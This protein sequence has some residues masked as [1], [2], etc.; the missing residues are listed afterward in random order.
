MAEKTGTPWASSMVTP[1]GLFSAYDLPFLPGFPVLSKRL[2]FL[3]P[4]F[5]TPLSRF[6]KAATRSWAKAWDRLRAEVGLPPTEGNP[7]VD[8]HSPRLHLA[9]FSKRLAG[10]QRDW[11]RRPPS[12]DSRS[13]MVAAGCRRAWPV[14]WTTGRGP[15]CSRSACRRPW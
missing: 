3:G 11:P 13:M 1:A 2:R 14:S 5:W 15:S 4:S 9:L 12:P 7:L 10:K 8:V 6:L